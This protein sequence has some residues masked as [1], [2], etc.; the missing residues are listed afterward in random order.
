MTQIKNPQLK[1]DILLNLKGTN[2]YRLIG[3]GCNV[4]IIADLGETVI[5]KVNDL[6]ENVEI[7]KSILK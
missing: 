2:Y 6:Y 7:Y 4:T 3:A 1:I 5:I